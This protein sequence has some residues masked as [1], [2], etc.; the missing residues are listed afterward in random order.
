MQTLPVHVEP[1][2]LSSF[3][4]DGV[5]FS[6]LEAHLL[7]LKA[8][9]A[10]GNRVLHL[11]QLKTKLD[12]MLAREDRASLAKAACSGGSEMTGNACGIGGIEGPARTGKIVPTFQADEV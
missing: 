4:P 2:P 9:P 5:S 8:L 7:R 11:H 10:H 3:D 1:P 6:F 12:A